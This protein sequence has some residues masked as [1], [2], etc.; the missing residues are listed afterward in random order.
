MII[1][2]CDDEPQFLEEL[3][4]YLEQYKK[5]EKREF[6]II[7]FTDGYDFLQKFRTE[8][9]IDVVILD[10]LMGSINGVNIAKEIRRIDENIK[11]IF[12]TSTFKYALEGYKVNAIRYILK[13]ISYK[14]LNTELS[15][16]LE[17]VEK[18]NNEFIFE[19]TDAGFNKIYLKDIVYIETSGR[20]T[21]IH[22]LSQSIISYRSM[23]EH[24]K[25]LGREFF[26]CHM[27]YIVNMNYVKNVKQLDVFLLDGSLIPVSKYRRKAF[28]ESLSD[29]LSKLL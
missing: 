23:K 17:L 14:K 26:R 15:Y 12:L 25:L 20:N 29:Y 18:E 9:N 1:A 4:K 21:L 11:I 13:P 19:K 27:S 28:I 22:T 10:V 7:E 6:S 3:H 5:D 24:E 2:I 8:Q 16:I